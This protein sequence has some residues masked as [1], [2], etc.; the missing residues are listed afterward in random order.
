MMTESARPSWWPKDEV[1]ALFLYHE[2][3]ELYEN[4]TIDINL[5][6]LAFLYTMLIWLPFTI[7][8]VAT[9]WWEPFPD[10]WNP[11][12]IIVL[13]LLM[14]LGAF[15]PLTRRLRS[16]AAEKVSK[17]LG[18]PITQEHTDALEK[19]FPRIWYRRR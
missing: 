5:R 18:V 15:L 12:L 7:A 14:F 17:Q 10:G 3:M 6:A 8:L 9:M 11:I 13:G 1:E 16:K 19:E 2:T 4:G